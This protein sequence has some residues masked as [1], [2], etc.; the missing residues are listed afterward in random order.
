MKWR[1]AL[2]LWLTA[3]LSLFALNAPRA[4][5]NG[6]AAGFCSP[7]SGVVSSAT[8]SLIF[9]SASSQS[10][11]QTGKI[12]INQQKFAFGGWVKFTSVG[13]SQTLFYLGDGTANNQVVLRVPVGNTLILTGTTSSSNVLALTTTATFTDVTNWHHIWVT[14]D[15]TQATAANRAFIWYDGVAIASYS[16]AT[17]PAQNAN[18]SNNF[19]ATY[20]IGANSTPANFLN[21]KLAQAYYI[22]GQAQ[23]PS[24]VLTGTP[25]LPKAYSGTY[26]GTFDFFLPFSNGTSTTTLGTDGSGESNNW[27]LN[28][29]TTAN[30]S[31]DHP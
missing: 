23:Q 15:T 6:C 17:Y 20:R 22:D 3:I 10:L 7:T 9:T 29:M 5:F 21:A 28:N 1:V 4:Q 13:I 8:N 14:V 19:A 12:T 16:T 27:T 25:G 31:T 2:A 18:L 11:S 26:S 24:A 30:Q